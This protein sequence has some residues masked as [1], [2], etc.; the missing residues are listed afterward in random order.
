MS[1]FEQFEITIS[2]REQAP[3]KT[4][5]YVHGICNL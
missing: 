5:I 3:Q 1:L 4:E 2:P